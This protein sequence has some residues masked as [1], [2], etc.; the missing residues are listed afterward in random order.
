MHKLETHFI[1]ENVAPVGTERIAVMKHDGTGVPVKEVGYIPLGS[2]DTG[3]SPKSR[4]R[5]FLALADIHLTYK[6]ANADFGRAL[7]F[8]ADPRNECDFVCIAGDLTATG[9][10][11]TGGQME[12]YR[13]MVEPYDDVFP[14][15]AIAGNHEA[16]YENDLTHDTV[17]PYTGQNLYYAF[18]EGGDVYVMLGH[19]GG[20]QEG[21]GGW[22]PSEFLSAEELQWLYE[23]LEANR[24]KRCF[25]FSHEL[26]H[27]HEVGNP[28][29]LFRDRAPIWYTETSG[30]AYD[31]GLGKAVV[32]LLKHYKNTVLFHGHSHTRFEMQQIAPTANY[33]D[34]YGYTSIHIPS[35]AAPRDE[36]ADG[37]PK[38]LEDL[39]ARSEGYVVDV[40]DDCIVL[41]GRDF[42][43]YDAETGVYKD[44]HCLPIATYKIDT[45]LQI[46]EA[47]TFVDE[48][49][50]IP[51]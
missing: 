7:D 45:P 15:Y 13:D 35:L 32:A 33:S 31:N 20:Y 44:P 51:T 23:T 21:A 10:T 3:L 14:I 25:V 11:G 47:G 30:G 19:Y 27:E 50:L 28:N 4:R 43:E 37:S 9:S 36:D 39:Y 49:G 24:N 29:N 17:S 6:T 8:A 41:N 38:L 16:S 48:T 42:G 46:V 12:L 5:R 40:Y 22:R 2:L 26:P 18:Q 1:P 34:K